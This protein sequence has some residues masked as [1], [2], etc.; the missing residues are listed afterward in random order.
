MVTTQPRHVEP[1]AAPEGLEASALLEENAR[2][3]AQVE[4]LEVRVHTDAERRRALLH[5]MSDLHDTNTR[6]ADQRKAMLHILVDYEQDRRRLARQTERLDNARRALLHILQDV[7]RANQRLEHSRKAMIHIMGDLR[8]TEEALRCAHDELEQRVRD[9]TAELTQANERL[10]WEMA[11]RQQAEAQLRQQQEIL[12]QHEKLAAMG[13]LLASVAH[14]LQNPLSIVMVQ[15]ELLW[16]EIQQGPMAEQTQVITQSAERCARIVRNFLTLARQHPP[17]RQWVDLNHVVQEAVELLIYALRVDTIEVALQLAPDLPVCAADPHQLH[18]VVI[19]L[20]TNAHQ[21]LR[22][23]PHPR[24]LTFTTCTDAART[25]VVLEVA[26]TG[27]GMRPEIQDRIFEPFFTTKPPGVG[28]G[29]GLPL[30]RGIVEGHEGTLHVQS[31]PGQGTVFRIELPV[32]DELRAEPAAPAVLAPAPAQAQAMLVVDDEPEI[33]SALAHLLRRSGY[34]VDT[35]ANGRVALDKLQ[36]RSYDL[37]LCDLRM[38]ELDGPGLY[39]EL[40]A[41]YPQLRRRVIFLTGDTLSSE[42][43]EFLE[44]AGVAR[45]SKP[46]R[47]AEVRRAVRQALEAL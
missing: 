39:R 6:L 46:F 23:V 4:Q 37:I 3:R 44:T 16:E 21:A 15:A 27:P 26:D 30:C 31:Q 33:A 29:L 9:R 43:R 8:Q 19:N 40:E 5:I 22:E 41:C 20:V 32:G 35:A 24:R 2:L 10:R 17:E 14:E 11:E 38:P 25:H 13:S 47:A 36:E 18:Q 7:H 28:T 1:D 34:A 12:F 42:A 45:L